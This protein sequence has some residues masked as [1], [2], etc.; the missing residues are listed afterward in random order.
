M[1]KL[2]LHFKSIQYYNDNGV[3]K[4]L[5]IGIK[6]ALKF[7]KKNKKKRHIISLKLGIFNYFLK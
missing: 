2:V 4:V 7:I 3:R 5:E 6:K 1:K